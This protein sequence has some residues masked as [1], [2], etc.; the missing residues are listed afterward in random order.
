M[1]AEAELSYRLVELTESPAVQRLFLDVFKHTLSSDLLHWKYGAGRGLNWGVFRQ[2]FL[3]L[4]CGVVFREVLWQDRAH[5]AAQLVDL[6]AAG[7]HSGL[8]RNN[9]PFSAL[10]RIILAS[11]REPNNPFALAFG[12]PSDRAMKLGERLGV[13]R[14]VDH[15][16]LLEFSARRL[17]VGPRA[18]EVNLSSIQ[19]QLLDLLWSRMARE[20]S[21][22][23]VG[24]RDASYLHWRYVVHPENRYLF[25]L[26]LSRWRRKPIGLLVLTP[27]QHRFEV[28]DFVCAWADTPELILAAQ[29]W[30]SRRE[31]SS[32]Q[33]YLTTSFAKQL[34][35]YSSL[36]S[37]SEFRI[38]ANPFMP[39]DELLALK[40]KWFLTGGDSDFH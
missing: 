13:Y 8:S 31:G 9:S 4:H 24:T 33:L 17:R 21:S 34:A 39:N 30:L 1:N 3:E 10:M 14:A 23:A 32:L 19:P 16:Q 2:D 38:M 36:S 25:L 6:M 12:F 15:W 40:G 27:C 22:Y 29:D 5:R 26:A 11:L 20:L 35:P 37:L 18:V 7:K 28:V